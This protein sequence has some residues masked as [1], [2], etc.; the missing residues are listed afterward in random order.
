MGGS[1]VFGDMDPGPFLCFL[2]S[3]LPQSE[4][5]SC[6]RCSHQDVPKATGPNAHG[7]KPLKLSQNK[8]FF[9]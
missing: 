4:Q 6:T 3:L 7:L 9:L 5:S 8:S 1:Y 2:V